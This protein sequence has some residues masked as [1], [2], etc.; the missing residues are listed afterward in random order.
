MYS[1]THVEIREQIKSHFSLSFMWVLSGLVASTLTYGVPFLAS[2]CYL[3]GQHY[4]GEGVV[5]WLVCFP[6]P[7]FLK[8]GLL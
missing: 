6:S 4:L 8:Q 7:P 3:F 1:K 5:C 2:H